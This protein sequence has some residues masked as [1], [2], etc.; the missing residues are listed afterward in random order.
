VE[1][2]TERSQAKE[3]SGAVASAG[4][5]DEITEITFD[6]IPAGTTMVGGGEIVLGGDAS[7]VGRLRH[8]G[9][10][11][12]DTKPPAVYEVSSGRYV[13][14]APSTS[15]GTV[16]PL[17]PALVDPLCRDLDGCSLVFQMID[18]FVSQPGNVI[19][20]TAHMFLS[21]TS[22]WWQ[23]SQGVV[24]S[25]ANGATS[26]WMNVALDECRFT[27][28]DTASLLAVPATSLSFG[29]PQ[30]GRCLRFLGRRR[31]FGE[32]F[33]VNSYGTGFQASP[34]V[35][36]AANGDFLIAWEGQGPG[37]D[38]IGGDIQPLRVHHAPSSTPIDLITPS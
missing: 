1:G 38:G 20:R 18:R 12:Q 22:Q 9:L 28:A 6:S 13:V 31:A 23:L 10:L 27:D 11:Q 29:S 25:D 36:A 33:E 24:G 21:Q 37:G 5:A 2:A 14:E 7:V 34:S 3:S 30:P 19:S 17:D 16:V 26:L 32:E 15:V 8:L 4:N 35:A